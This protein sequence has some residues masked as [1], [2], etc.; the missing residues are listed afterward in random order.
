MNPNVPRR[1]LLKAALAT[2]AGAAASPFVQA[3]P[4]VAP[5]SRDDRAYWLHTLERITTPV[6]AAIA[7]QQLRATMPVELAPGGNAESR[8]QCSH[9]EAFARLLCGL[10][11]WLELEGLTGAE[12]TLQTHYREQA[13]A[14]IQHGTNPSSPDYLNFGATG[15]SLVDTAFLALAIVRAPTQLWKRLDPPT[16]RNLVAALIVTRKILPGRS[17]WL[18]F[19]AMIEACLCTLGEDWDRM[20][21]DYAI[22]QHEQWFVGDGT[23]GDG[24]HFHWDYYNSFVI[25][26]MLLTILDA[27]AKQ[28][29]TWE[30]LRPAI[31]A[32]AQRYAV[33]QERLIS[34]EATFPAIGRSLAYRFGAFHHLAEVSLRRQLPE[35]LTPEQVRSA[36][37]AVMRRMIEMPG[38]FDGKGWLTIGFAGHQPSIGEP[39]IST[40]SCYLCA[41]AWLPLGLPATDRF[42][43]APG[44]PWTAQK[45][46]GGNDVKADHASSA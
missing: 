40:G 20:R 5:T 42:W 12:A 37:T 14:G 38:T 39:Y 2:A 15:Q 19:S 24:P 16:Q 21:I 41:A 33:I 45:I 30:P 22:Q 36:L 44:Q 25:Q 29:Q 31:L 18:L 32:R 34:P 4:T 26:P 8:R 6:L 1:A 23:Y 9:L 17:N 35:E 11:P 13:R 7:S 28:S 43:S 3:L 46:W 10:A 27:V